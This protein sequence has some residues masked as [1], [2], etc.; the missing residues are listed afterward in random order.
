MIHMFDLAK[1]FLSDAFSILSPL[2]H[3]LSGLF[4]WTV[5]AKCWL[6]ESVLIVGVFCVLLFKKRN[7]HLSGSFVLFSMCVC[8]TGQKL[9]HMNAKSYPTTGSLVHVSKSVVE[10]FYQKCPHGVA[11]EVTGS[12]EVKVKIK[13]IVSPCHSG[14]LINQIL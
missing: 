5:V 11:R 2:T 3:C 1:P 14:M 6:K 9:F 4:I 10:T 13:Y 12:T 8:F 7:D